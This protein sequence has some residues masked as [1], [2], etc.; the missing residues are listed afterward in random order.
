VGRVLAERVRAD[1]FDPLIAVAGDLTRMI[2]EDDLRIM[3]E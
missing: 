3:R 1:A 2:R